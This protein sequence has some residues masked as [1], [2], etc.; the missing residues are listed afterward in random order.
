[1]RTKGFLTRH[2]AVQVFL[3]V[4]ALSIAVGAP[5]AWGQPKT[6][7]AVSYLTM[8]DRELALIAYK[9]FMDRVNE[10]F[11]ADVRIDYTGGPEVIPPG[12]QM[13]ALS[14]GVIQLLLTPGY[15]TSVVPEVDATLVAE[16]TPTEQRSVGFYDLMVRIHREKLG[17]VPL[18]RADY[19]TPFFLFTNAKVERIKDFSGLKF[20]SNANYASFF[21]K[22]GIVSV[23][24]P[25]GE[26]YTALERGLVSGFPLPV[27][28]SQIGLQTVTKT[29][30]DHPWWTGGSMYIYTNG[31]MWD[32]LPK[33]TQDGIMETAKAV[34]K[35][36]MPIFNKFY[37]E[38]RNRLTAAGMKFVKLAPP[39]G[40]NLVK[41]A[42]DVKWDDILKKSPQYGAQMQA[43][44]KKK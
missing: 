31:K 42:T 40:D 15:H 34:E 39:D 17:V 7:K 32:S 19:G 36:M 26:L 8:S 23:N 6:I 20:R 22:L 21:A 16:I 41:M 14:K 43:M 18:L 44:L 24:M 35:D 2:G 11:K 3:L 10:K 29:M 13:N 12:E 28:I 5:A 30:I 25:I 38:E 27:F 37:T 9:M 1:M 33:A 4:L